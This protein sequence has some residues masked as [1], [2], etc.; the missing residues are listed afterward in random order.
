MD[1][2][3]ISDLN[4]GQPRSARDAIPRVNGAVKEVHLRDRTS[5]LDGVVRVPMHVLFN[6]AGRLCTRW[7]KTIK[8]T[9]VQQNFIQKLVS[10]IYGY[11]F[12]ILFFHAM[13]FPKHF[14]CNAKHD[15]I[16]TLGCTPISCFRKTTYPD[17]FA[18]NLDQARMYSTHA[19]SSTSTDDN[20]TLHLY[21]IQANSA[22]SGID[23]RL[24]TRSGFRVSTTNSSGLKLGESDKSQLDENL[25]SG[26]GAM[27]LAA[28]AHKLGMVVFLIYTPNQADHPGLRHLHEWKDSKRWT[29][30][31]EHYE[32]YQTSLKKDYDISM[33]MAY[34]HMMTRCWLEVRKFWLE[35]IIYSTSTKLRRVT[36]AFFRDEYQECSGNLCHIHGLL[37]LYKG[38]M[39][40]EEFLDFVCSLQKNSVGDLV[41]A[42]EVQEFIDNGLFKNEADWV[43]CKAKAEQVL[44]HTKHN[45]RCLRRVNYTG[46]Y[47]KDFVCRKLHPVFDS[48]NCLVDEFK[49]L[50]YSYSDACLGILKSIG[51]YSPPGP[52]ETRGTFHHDILEPKRHH[53][54]VHP[55]ARENMSP[56]MSEHFAFT[57][58]MQNMQVITGTNGVTRYVVK[59]S[60]A[61]LSCLHRA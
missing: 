21:S 46:V 3:M 57:L 4:D 7:N 55:G 52:G 39:D 48:T 5:T 33:E 26:Q 8:G 27:N 24:A 40:N 36:H 28:A 41:G 19:S 59:V 60:Y 35:F 34:T 22:S 54:A 29:A 43:T 49:N 13:L 45:S 42:D 61:V 6:Q 14:W 23:S 15:P 53:G 37:G 51:L 58:S 11:S 32:E 31:L 47:D 20:F 12:P 10:T 2:A 38:D 17:G 25:D 1:P 44:S 50:P 18:S 56:V 16:A 9:Q 30:N